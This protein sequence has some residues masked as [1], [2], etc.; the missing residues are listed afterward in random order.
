MS[1]VRFA[2][3]ALLWIATL[4]FWG[5][6]PATMLTAADEHGA[7]VTIRQERHG[8]TLVVNLQDA[9]GHGELVLLKSP[10]ASWPKHLV[11]RITPGAVHRLL[12]RSEAGILFTPVEDNDPT[13]RDVP[14]PR[15][16][17]S[18]RTSAI[19]VSWDQ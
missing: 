18:A 12:V 9:T 3:S 8:G 17:Y 16:L 19:K 2:A 10:N 6:T 11:I 1:P 7:S 14:L 15:S 5:C 4:A 13:P